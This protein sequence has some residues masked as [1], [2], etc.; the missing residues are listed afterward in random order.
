MFIV[1]VNLALMYFIS[2]VIGLLY[3]QGSNKE[4]IIHIIRVV[5]I[6]SRDVL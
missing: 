1:V 3:V 5:E 6:E 4:F 2:P